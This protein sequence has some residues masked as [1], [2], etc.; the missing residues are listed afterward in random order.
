MLHGGKDGVGCNG[1]MQVIDNAMI[2][3]GRERNKGNARGTR[4]LS[5]ATMVRTSR[6]SRILTRQV[7]TESVA[8]ACMAHHF[9]Q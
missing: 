2:Q 7:A 5:P 8:H 6:V 3:F 4:R 9:R 1:Q